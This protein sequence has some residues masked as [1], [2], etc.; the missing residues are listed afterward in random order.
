VIDPACL[1]CDPNKADAQLQR[2]E[3]WNDGTWRLT[4]ALR[5]EVLGFCY[6]EPVR[7]V[8]HIEDLEGVEAATFGPALARAAAALKHQTEA[9]LV[10]LY[11]FGEGIAHLHVHLAPHRSG[12]ALS[13]QIVRGEFTERKLP[14][15]A[16]EVV[17]D[18]FPLLEEDLI[19]ALAEGV[20]REL[21][22]SG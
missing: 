10:Y 11:V 9:E 6:L 3:V 1:L 13:D 8:S 18:D 7:H 5:S 15:G 12:D 4:M 21:R 22:E 19:K 14:G 20:S 17:S 16:T 2:V